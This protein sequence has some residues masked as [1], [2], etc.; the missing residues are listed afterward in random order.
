MSS[1]RA[2]PRVVLWLVIVAVGAATLLGFLVAWPLWRMG[3]GTFGSTVGASVIFICGAIFIG[4]EYTELERMSAACLEETGYDCVFSPSAFTRFAVYAGIALI[5]VF[6]L[7]DR[8]ISADRRA[9]R[10]R[11]PSEWN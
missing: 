1:L 3:H 7:F 2:L 8:G 11:F 9:Y 5:E 10:K 4:L 6:V